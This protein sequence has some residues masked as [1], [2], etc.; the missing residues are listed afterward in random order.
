MAK[1]PKTLVLLSGGLDS[2][3][4]A[5]FVA[6][7]MGHEVECLSI[8]Y[9]QRHRRELAAAEAIAKSLGARFDV[10]DI[11]SVGMLLEASA[12]TNPD[13]AVPEGHYAAENMAI[14]VVPNRN[15]TFLSIAAA[16]AASRGYYRIAAAVHSGDHYIYPDCRPEFVNSFRE[17][18]QLALG[19]SEFLVYTPFL[20]KTKA[21]IVSVGSRLG[22]PFELT[23]SCYKGGEKH[24]GRCGTCVERAEAFY[25]AGVP[26]PTEYED[27]DYWGTVSKHKGGAAS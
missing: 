11:S 22:V 21:D 7:E 3:T 2:S 4:L 23:W 25:L 13:V 10:V 17:T 9:G 14:T 16:V 12:L 1:R 18:V 5:Y 24:C 27:P 26:D 19:V 15:M 6:R 8:Y 20:L